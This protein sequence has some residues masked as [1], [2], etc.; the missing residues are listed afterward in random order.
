M[1]QRPRRRG[2]R[3]LVLVVLVVVVLLLA[4]VV[5]AETVGRSLAEDRIESE[6]REQLGGAGA[7]EATVEGFPF[8]T[9]VLAGSLERVRVTA[10]DLIVGGTAV[11]ADLVASGV[12]VSGSGTVDAMT[13]TFLLS[14]DAVRAGLSLP[15]GGDDTLTFGDDSITFETVLD[16]RIV[17]PSIRVALTPQLDGD[18]VVLRATSLEVLAGGG[19]FDVGS[20]VDPSRFDQTIC[21]AALL[22]AAFTLED[23]AVSPEGVALDVSGT[24]VP[25]SAEAL[26]TT[27]SC[28]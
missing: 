11:D 22:P 13:G 7:V 14:P 19:S 20:L 10:P 12:P 23:L 8:T 6:L 27:G 24:D 28:G 3:I 25:L 26:Q 1:P 4:A 21:A 5:V 15:D 2:R 18:E 17:E 9:Q 16:L